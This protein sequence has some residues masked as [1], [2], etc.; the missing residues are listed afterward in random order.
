LRS[1]NN[2]LLSFNFGQSGDDPKM[3]GDYDGD[4]KTDPAVYRPGAN[5]GDQST[6]YWLSSVDGLQH[7]YQFGQNGDFPVPGDFDADGKYDFTVQRN[8][9][10][11]GAVFYQHQT[12]AGDGAFWFGTPTDVVVPGYYDADCKTDIAVIRGISGQIG[13]YIRNSTSGSTSAYIF[14]NSATD[15]PTQGDYDGDGKTDIAVWR[16]NADPALD[17]FYWVRSIDGVTGSV[18]WGQNG[19]Y[20][21]ANFNA[22]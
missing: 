14:G 20:P 19:D 1:S 5:A 12:T 7:G 13:W 11:G 6:W 10:G 16:P 18:E 2:T 8:G 4:G 17:F 15:F 21:V 9:G 3:T 22:H